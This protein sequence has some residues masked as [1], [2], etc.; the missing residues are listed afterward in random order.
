MLNITLADASSTVGINL[1][2]VRPYAS[3]GEHTETHTHK[4]TVSIIIN[5]LFFKTLVKLS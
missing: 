2:H 3:V 1:E 4:D 5:T